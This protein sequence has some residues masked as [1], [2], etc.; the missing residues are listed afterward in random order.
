MD[1]Q[2][3]PEH[4]HRQ[5]AF[6]LSA[7]GYSRERSAVGKRLLST[8]EKKG[9]IS[10]QQA[11]DLYGNRFELIKQLSGVSPNRAR[12]MPVKTGTNPFIFLMP[13][14]R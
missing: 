12:P 4:H 14:W 10:F 7:G 2:C 9:L 8:L 3:H 5:L 11:R 1:R 13:L 6:C